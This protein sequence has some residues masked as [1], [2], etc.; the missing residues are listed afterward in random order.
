VLVTVTVTVGGAILVVE[1]VEEVELDPQSWVPA[2]SVLTEPPTIIS[3]LGRFE[4]WR[5]PWT[6][7]AVP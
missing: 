3:L 5:F 6:P 4:F 1:V 7:Q 2:D